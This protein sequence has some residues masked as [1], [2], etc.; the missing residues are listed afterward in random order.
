M[1]PV[2]IN[3]HWLATEPSCRHVHSPNCNHRPD[4]TEINLLLIHNISLPAGEFNTPY[5]EQLFTNT[6]DCQAHHSF[7]DLE[8]LRV[9][10]HVMINRH[11]EATQFVPFDKRAWHAGVSEFNGVKSCNDYSIGIELEGADEIAYTEAQ[12]Q[13]LAKIARQLM[14]QYP[15]ITVDRIVGHCDVA[16]GRKTD[17]GSAFDWNYFYHCLESK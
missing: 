1:I 6:L 13:Q 17:P 4:D 3:Q 10:S 15:A 2:S 5:I 14:V 9:S 8:A 7:H 11:G 12:Y 16:P